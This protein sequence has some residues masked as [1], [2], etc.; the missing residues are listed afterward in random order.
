M[1]I[2]DEKAIKFTKTMKIHKTYLSRS[3]CCLNSIGDFV[4]K[5]IQMHMSQ[6]IGCT[7]QHSRGVGKIPTSL[8]REWLSCTLQSQTTQYEST[9][10][11]SI[12]L[13]TN[14]LDLLPI[15]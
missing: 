9:A 3:Y 14:S 8:F 5:F 13:T 12:M 4:A 1:S 15:K 2:K 11:V 6:H 10:F 7:K